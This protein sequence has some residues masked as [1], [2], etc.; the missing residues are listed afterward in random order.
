[1]AFVTYAFGHADRVVTAQRIFTAFVYGGVLGVLGAA[2]PGPA[3]VARVAELAT[4]RRAAG[5]RGGDDREGQRLLTGWALLAR[6]R[7]PPLAVAC[8]LGLWLLLVP[9]LVSTATCS[10]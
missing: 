10:G 3:A 2:Q 9:S 4:D 6:N 1:V 7:I 5:H 8:S